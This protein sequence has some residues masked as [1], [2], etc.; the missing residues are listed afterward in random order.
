MLRA[1]I[2]DSN[3][4]ARGERRKHT[5][6]SGQR[7]VIE[8]DASHGAD[9]SKQP[10]ITILCR[11]VRCAIACRWSTTVLCVLLIIVN[12][13][14]TLKEKSYQLLIRSLVFDQ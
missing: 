8:R 9:A 6:I 4:R 10:T 5:H 3:K 1:L 2:S 12:F 11:T 13:D 14:K 7:S